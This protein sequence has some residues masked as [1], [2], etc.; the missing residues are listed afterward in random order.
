M[1]FCQ[2]KLICQAQGGCFHS[3]TREQI[4]C[5]EL[6]LRLQTSIDEF[7]STNFFLSKLK[8]LFLKRLSGNTRASEDLNSL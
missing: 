4:Y 6:Q 8:I 5:I 7:E 3:H 1:S 2:G